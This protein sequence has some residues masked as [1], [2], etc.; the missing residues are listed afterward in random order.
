VLGWPLVKLVSLSVHEYGLA[1][2]FGRP[3]KF[4]GTEN[5]RQVLSDPQLWSVLVRTVVFCLGTVV[6]TMVAGMLVALLVARLGRVL[7]LSVL[8]ALLL[9]WAMPPVS[10]TIVWQWMFDTQYGVVNWLLAHADEG[11]DRHNWLANQ[12]SFLTVAALVVVW[13]GVPFVAF[14]LYGGLT[15][16][17]REVQE[18]ALVDGASAV[19]RFRNVTVPYLRPIITILIS[20]SVLWNFRVFTQI[21]VLQKAGGI[22][23]ETDVLGVYAYRISVGASHFDV[24]SAIAVVMVLIVLLL[25]AV[26]LRQLAGQEREL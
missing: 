17:P 5:Y 20:L 11:Y 21:Y 7:R 9:A 10:A 15:Q 26:Y 19:Q 25:T 18:A 3:A 22:S 4:V 2:Q 13:M 12:L 24:G 14:T 6:L 23:S 8:G 1:Q 16:I